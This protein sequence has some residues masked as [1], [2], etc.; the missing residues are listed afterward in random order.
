[1]ASPS[2]LV[3]GR[4]LFSQ[5]STRL[6]LGRV[7]RCEATAGPLIDVRCYRRLLTPEQ[8]RTSSPCIWMPLIPLLAMKVVECVGGGKRK[9]RPE[10]HRG[11]AGQVLLSVAILA[12]TQNLSCHA[13]EVKRDKDHFATEIFV[14]VESRQC[15]ARQSKYS[16]NRSVS[17]S[18]SR[19]VS[20]SSWMESPSPQT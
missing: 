1:M 3:S 2:T 20:V 13:R 6:A 16:R 8:Y 12:D 9:T 11:E 18:L 5:R 17:V 19:R 10:A 4:C 15:S 7:L 14:L